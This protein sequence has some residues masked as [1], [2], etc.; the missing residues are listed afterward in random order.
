VIYGV[1][2]GE[3]RGDIFFDRELFLVCEVVLGALEGDEF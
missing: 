3:V 2:G 1:I